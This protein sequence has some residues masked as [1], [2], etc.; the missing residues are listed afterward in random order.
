MIPPDAQQHE[1]TTKECQVCFESKH[2]DL[3]PL[4]DFAGGCSCLSDACLACLQEQIKS[5]V[6]SKEWSESTI[7]CPICNRALTH[8]EIEEYADVE[9]LAM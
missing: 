5:Q 6:T 9:T 7:N 8:Q 3:F 4:S 2:I 1:H